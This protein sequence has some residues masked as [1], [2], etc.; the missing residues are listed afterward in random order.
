MLKGQ[1]PE[2]EFQRRS[3]KK[4]PAKGRD[5]QKTKQKGKINLK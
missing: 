1:L 5:F 3:T 4:I 2:I